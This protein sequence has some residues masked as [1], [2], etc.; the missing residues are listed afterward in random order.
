VAHAVLYDITIVQD[1]Q[2]GKPLSAKQSACV[3]V[4]KL[5][6]V[7]GK[8]PAWM[9]YAMQALTGVLP[10][11]RQCTLDGQTHMVRS[12]V[13]APVLTEFLAALRRKRG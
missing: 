13:L 1:N 2:Q 11:A 7:G 3:T 8:S 6:M 5:V 10:N 9:R 4:P 12:N